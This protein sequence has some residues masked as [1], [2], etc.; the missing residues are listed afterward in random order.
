MDFEEL[1]RRAA[2]TTQF[3]GATKPF[4]AFG[5]ELW[6]RRM[7]IKLPTRTAESR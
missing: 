1:F 3:S 2:A 7:V 5:A 6:K 4:F